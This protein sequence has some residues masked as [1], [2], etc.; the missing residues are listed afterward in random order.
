VGVTEGEGWEWRRSSL[1]A[2]PWKMAAIARRTNN[3]TMMISVK[4][5]ITGRLAIR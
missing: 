1:R 4:R 5:R 2:G 3:T